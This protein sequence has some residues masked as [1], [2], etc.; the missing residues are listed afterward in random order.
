MNTKPTSVSRRLIGATAPGYMMVEV[1]V[2]VGIVF[3]LLGLGYMVLYRCIDN[4]VALRRNTEDIVKALHVAE[5]WRAD[6]R[7]APAGIQI[8]NSAD[9]QLLRLPTPAGAIL[10]RFASNSVSRRLADG[11]WVVLLPNVISSVMGAEQR[12]KVTVWRW[13]LELRS[14]S[15]AMVR[16]GRVRPLFTVLAVPRPVP[17]SLSVNP[18]F[19][20]HALACSGGPG[21]G[22]HALACSGGLEFGVHASAC[23]GGLE[24][25]A[26]ALA[27]SQGPEF[28][29]HALACSGGLGGDTDT[30]KGEHPTDSESWL[31]YANFLVDD[32]A[33]AHEQ[34]GL[35]LS[36]NAP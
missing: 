18:P 26:P 5:R 4:S 12:Q 35:N 6:V 11:P 29:V 17:A 7:A 16:P 22:V 34:C 19:G 28:G 2:Y 8:E 36:V 25:G 15:K 24:F 20:V 21:L 14:Q 13:E 33:N 32:S 1:L 10:Y 3:V 30:L 27:C 23:S 9:G 31:R